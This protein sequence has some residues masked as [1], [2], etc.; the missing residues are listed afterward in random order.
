VR[1]LELR[2]PSRDAVVFAFWIALA[3]HL[4]DYFSTV[5]AMSYGAE[6]AN[7][8]IDAIIQ[9]GGNWLFLLYKLTGVLFFW[10]LSYWNKVVATVLAAPFFFVALSN[11]F[12]GLEMAG[13]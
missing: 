11:T 3:A 2:R 9:F 13:M 7:P 8:I 12:I 5:F 1:F 6:E 10:A 4:A